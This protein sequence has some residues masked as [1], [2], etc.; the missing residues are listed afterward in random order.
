MVKLSGARTQETDSKHSSHLNPVVYRSL[1][2]LIFD[3]LMADEDGGED[4]PL[5]GTDER[6][7]RSL[8]PAFSE[9]KNAQWLTSAVARLRGQPNMYTAEGR[10][11]WRR[12][13]NPR[14]DGR[15]AQRAINSAWGEL[16]ELQP[17][18]LTVAETMAMC[19]LN[20]RS[21]Q[22]ILAQSNFAQ[23]TR[24][25]ST[26]DEFRQFEQQ[27]NTIRN[28]SPSKSLAMQSVELISGGSVNA[29]QNLQKI[30]DLERA[31]SILK[32]TIQGL[33]CSLLGG[34]PEHMIHWDPKDMKVLTGLSRFDLIPW[35]MTLA[36]GVAVDEA[37]TISAHLRSQMALLPS[38]SFG[39][40]D[41]LS[42]ED[43]VKVTLCSIIDITGNSRT[44]STLPLLVQRLQTGRLFYQKWA[45]QPK[46][47]KR[48]PEEAPERG[49]W[50]R[51]SSGRWKWDFNAT[52]NAP[53]KAKAPAQAQAPAQSAPAPS[54]RN[55]SYNSYNNNNLR[56]FYASV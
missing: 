5:V 9:P 48:S 7:S 30:A 29:A 33:Q 53:P 12:I 4:A 52:K 50:V 32:R 37:S 47:Q 22:Q 8:L 11:V 36:A 38:S 26:D 35:G 15:L 51:D 19:I 3:A 42:Y 46:R 14:A 13:T 18:L 55:N 31:E 44:P 45:P 43:A 34:T 28:L 2:I 41:D 10:D 1:L 24:R 56:Y 40:T 17:R 20:G 39:V 27:L 25:P 21:P 49:D 54:R 16:G 6:L 23:I